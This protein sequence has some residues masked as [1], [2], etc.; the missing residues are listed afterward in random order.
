LFYMSSNRVC[1]LAGVDI[2]IL[3]APMTFIANA[4]LAAAV[5]EAGGLGIIETASPQGRDDLFAVRALTDRPVGANL[6][7]KMLGGRDVIGTL[8][9]AGIRFVTTSAGDPAVF[10]ERLHDAGITVFHVVGSLRAARKAEDAGVDGLVVEGV[11]GG[12][13]KGA[14]G[15]STMVLLPLV[16]E[17][18]TLPIVSA[19]GIC[20]ARS[21][22]AAFVLGADGVQMGTRMLAS[23]ESP[24]HANFKE[25]VVAAA[26]TDTLLVSPQGLPTMRVL[27]TGLTETVQRTG[28]ASG[29]ADIHKL[30]FDGDMEASLPNTGQVAGR[31]EGVRP[32]AAIIGEMLEGCRVALD[33]AARRVQAT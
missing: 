27:R 20:D 15:A 21:M 18:T 12:G 9:E 17:R 28:V 14:T 7:I 29:F 30:Y 26:D 19:G 10:T 31:I 22:A 3:Q 16:A 4:T 6:A 5:S 23:L 33:D 1:T 24:V 13:F 8:V 2:P 32:V 11:E 25:A